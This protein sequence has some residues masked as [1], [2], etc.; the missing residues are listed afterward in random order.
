MLKK[1]TVKC[2]VYSYRSIQRAVQPTD[3]KN[4][5]WSKLTDLWLPWNEFEKPF[6]IV[7]IP[8]TLPLF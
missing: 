6:Q 1:D 7:K 4:I 5:I 2:G 3:I 8:K